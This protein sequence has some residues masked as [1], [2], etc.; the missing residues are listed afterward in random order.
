MWAR[1]VCYVTLW[2]STRT[3]TLGSA[4]RKSIIEERR[5]DPVTGMAQDV[6]WFINSIAAIE[7]VLTGHG[8]ALGVRACRQ[9]PW[10]STCKSESY[11]AWIDKDLSG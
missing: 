7:G 3:R 4:I 6:D 2:T 1:A 11:W 10:I 8:S 9:Q 5:R